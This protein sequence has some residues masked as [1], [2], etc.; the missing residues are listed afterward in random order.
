M[1][2]K[3]LKHINGE[4]KS[5]GEVHLLVGS[6]HKCKRESKKPTM[7]AWGCFFCDF[8]KHLRSWKLGEDFG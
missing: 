8:R 6:E 5:K 4:P 2:N 1:T 7:E 3:A